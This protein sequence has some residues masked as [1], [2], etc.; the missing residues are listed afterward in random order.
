MI[1]VKFIN[2]RMRSGDGNALTDDTS[3]HQAMNKDGHISVK[4]SV[5]HI[6]NTRAARGLPKETGSVVH[7]GPWN[8]RLRRELCLVPEKAGGSQE[9]EDERD[10][11][12]V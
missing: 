9:A 11:D 5:K 3:R 12:L 1:E 8:N 4:N 6:S 7:Q 10:E 2:S